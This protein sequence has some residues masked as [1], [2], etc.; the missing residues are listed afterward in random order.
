MNA[1]VKQMVDRFLGW[2]LPADFNPDGGIRFERTGH[3]FGG[4]TFVREVTG[5]NLLTATQ[6]TEMVQ[7][8]LAPFEMTA[9]PRPLEEWSEE[10]GN[11]LWWAWNGEE[12]FGEP[13]Y[14]GSPLD[15]GRTYEGSLGGQGLGPITL[16]GWPGYHTHWTPL[17]P[18]PPSPAA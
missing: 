2:K 5:T 4:Q 10:H 6:A 1:L 11:V 17:P 14:V 7:H 18:M 3:G 16:G 12:W 15:L 13:P 9:A 8:M